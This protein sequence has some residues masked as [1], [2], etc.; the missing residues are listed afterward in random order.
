M[1]SS[2]VDTSAG[3][4]MSVVDPGGNLKVLSIFQPELGSQQTKEMRLKWM[5][6]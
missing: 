1:K 2:G 6:G 5:T 3:A 4:K